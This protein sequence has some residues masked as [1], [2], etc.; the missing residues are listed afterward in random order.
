MAI[1]CK[2]IVKEDK[3]ATFNN[4][5]ET[6]VLKLNFN[7]GPTCQVPVSTILFGVL[8]FWPKKSE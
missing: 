4:L 8:K 5:I 3:I 6:K 1:T 2:V 7:F